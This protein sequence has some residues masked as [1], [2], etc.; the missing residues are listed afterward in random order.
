[1]RNCGGAYKTFGQIFVCQSLKK[2]GRHRFEFSATAAVLYTLFTDCFSLALD[3]YV[4]SNNVKILFDTYVTYPVMDGKICRGIILENADGVRF[5]LP[6]PSSTQAVT[7]VIMHRAGVPCV[8][9]EN[10]MSYI[11]HGFDVESAKEFVNSKNM[12]KFREWRNSG[13]DINGNGHPNG[14]RLFTAQ[15][16]MR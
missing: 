5:T 2:V 1:M 11:V 14:M 12:W 8:E 10:Y 16:P 13:S 4:L 6:K 15:A 3:E 7:P 9:G